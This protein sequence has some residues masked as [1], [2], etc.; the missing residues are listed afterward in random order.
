MEFYDPGSYQ[1]S[2]SSQASTG[3]LSEEEP[4]L[5]EELGINVKEIIS[6]ALW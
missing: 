5:L 1:S 4:P 3:S 2:Y 6:H